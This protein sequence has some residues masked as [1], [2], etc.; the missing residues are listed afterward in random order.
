[1]VAA[2]IVAEG[3]AMT[4][5][6]N[7]PGPQATEDPHPHEGP[8]VSGAEMRDLTRLRRSSTD[9]R[10]AGVAGGLGRHLDI[11]P[12]ILRVAFV[13]LTF[14][15]GAGLLLYIAA[16]L[17]VPDDSTGRAP[18]Q[19][20]A[21]TRTIALVGV[22]ILAVLVSLGDWGGW[23]WFPWPLVL[24]AVIAWLVLSNRNNPPAPPVTPGGPVSDG[25]GT[26]AYPSADSGGQP[27]THTAVLPPAPPRNPR[28][29]GPI[30][31]WFTMALTALA[32][33][34]L[35]IVDLAGAPVADSAYPALA[36]GTIAAM[37]LVG[38]V[39]GRAG[40]LILVGLAALVALVGATAAERWDTADVTERPTVAA[41]VDQE[42]RNGAGELV[43]DLTG[44]RDLEE[45]DGRTLEVD[46][47]LGRVEIIVPGDLD[48]HVD[49][50]VGGPGSIRLFGDQRDGFN[51]RDEA[52]A[53]GGP[54]APSLQIDAFV[55]VGEI[56]V[57][58]R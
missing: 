45:L 31:F 48:V 11:D 13:V 44:V 8:R 58:Q 5:N 4:E 6:Q 19:T 53:D 51:V 28:K 17:L 25:G 32:L 57:I 7:D 23:I 37:L 10:V 2:P 35:G 30:L 46:G 21:R 56:E 50:E 29:R 20:D 15:G 40:G 9:K 41:D 14:F 52:R 27:P 16:W 1:M 12:V 24:V 47:G 39:Y 26:T 38:S 3:G 49:A 33:G 54:D 43:L 22:G 34:T 42:Y 18:L 36:L 55:G